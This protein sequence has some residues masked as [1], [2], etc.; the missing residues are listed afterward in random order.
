MKNQG[1]KKFFYPQLCVSPPT[2]MLLG[3]PWTLY[4]INGLSID[5]LKWPHLA[6]SSQNVKFITGSYQV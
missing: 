6:H 1:A 5:F 4:Y 2:E 3:H